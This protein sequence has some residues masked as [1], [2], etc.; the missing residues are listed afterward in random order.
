[1]PCRALGC[2]V[3]WAVSAIM[4]VLTIVVAG[5]A[6][7]IAFSIW[8]LIHG[9]DPAVGSESLSPWYH[10]P[11]KEV[12]SPGPQSAGRPSGPSHVSQRPGVGK[13]RPRRPHRGSRTHVC[14]NRPATVQ[15]EGAACYH[16]L[17]IGPCRGLSF[18]ND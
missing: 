1:M 5:F 3:K 4:W 17:G 8:I 10:P 16:D 6:V 11:A 13:E 7:L 2:A 9:Y 18:G 12:V 15:C 14:R